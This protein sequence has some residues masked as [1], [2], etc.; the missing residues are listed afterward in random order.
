MLFTNGNYFI[1]LAAVFFV[2][3]LLVRWRLPR[4]CFLLA[5]SYYFYALWNPR[6]LALLFL[7]STVDFLNAL[8][9]HRAQSRALRKLFLS[10]S[11]VGN[12]GALV[13]FKYFNFFSASLTDLLNK[14]GWHSS[15]PIV[16]TLVLPL[17]LSF[18]AFRSLSYVIDVY[19]GTIEP[20][21]RFL[22]YLTFVAFFPTI[23]A[24]PLARAKDLLPQFNLKPG[25]SNEEGAQALFLIL[26]GLVKKIA[27]A[28]FLAHNLV[29]RVF[30]QP[31]LY[32]SL[33]TLVAIYGYALQIYCDFSGYTDI[34]IGSALLLGLKLPVNF[35]SSARRWE[36]RI[37]RGSRYIRCSHGSAR[38]FHSSRL[39]RP[40]TSSRRCWRQRL[41]F[42]SAASFND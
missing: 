32:S 17:G 26:L 35:N 21:R 22:D 1:F 12:I 19:R 25:L 10:L 27:I 3:W 29:D 14:V 7:L 15:L 36:L 37:R 16:E 6:F 34:A 20:T 31:Q 33:E 28:D 5:A 30:D 2:Y 13:T 23:I 24:G 8:G 9:I 11:V 18:I 40:S 39:R 41:S 4:V 38:V 42:S